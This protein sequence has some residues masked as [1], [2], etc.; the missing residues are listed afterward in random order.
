MMHDVRPLTRR[1]WLGQASAAALGACSTLGS[2]SLLRAAH[3]AGESAEGS[4]LIVAGNQTEPSPLRGLLVVDP[5]AG[6]WR[7][8]AAEGGLPARLSPDGRTLV[9][10]KLERDGNGFESSLWLAS[11]EGNDEPR[12]LA[13]NGVWALWSPDGRELLIASVSK[14]KRGEF[15]SVLIRADGSSRR[16]LDL[17]RNEQV[18]DW[19]ADGQWLLTAA[20][21]TENEGGRV[22][23]V[24]KI[25]SRKFEGTSATLILEGDRNGMARFAPDGSRVILTRADKDKPDSYSLWLC[26][27]DG[28]DMRKLVAGTPELYPYFCCWSPDGKQLAADMSEIERGEDGNP[29]STRRRVQLFSAEGEPGRKIELP[30]AQA[31]PLDWR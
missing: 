17:P 9:Y 10:R 7:R 4:K 8:V 12:K 16:K 11:L 20:T 13:E 19:S 30:Q 18:L 23:S 22:R 21:L 14:E 3:A 1:Q 5:R 26:Q 6:T 28:T 31:I 2:C 27:R 29:L 25:M 24:P 15:E